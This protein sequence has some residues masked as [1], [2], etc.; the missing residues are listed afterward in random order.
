M[1]VTVLSC[2]QYDEEKWKKLSRQVVDQLVS[3]LGNQKVNTHFDR[4]ITTVS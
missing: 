2:Y 1:L 3:H 4:R